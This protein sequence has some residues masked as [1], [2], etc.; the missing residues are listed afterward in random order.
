MSFGQVWQAFV[1]NPVITIQTKID[2]SPASLRRYD[3]KE[4]VICVLL[5][6]LFRPDGCDDDAGTHER[7]AEGDDECGELHDCG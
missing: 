6:N 4:A 1:S 2:Y 5:N 3:S 7:D